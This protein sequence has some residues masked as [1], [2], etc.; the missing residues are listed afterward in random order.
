M[1]IK[2][3][4]CLFFLIWIEKQTHEESPEQWLQGFVWGQTFLW[5]TQQGQKHLEKE[6]HSHVSLDLGAIWYNGVC[7]G[8]DYNISTAE[9]LEWIMDRLS[10]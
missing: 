5:V 1:Q 7:K 9:L 8:S 4:K 2:S 3:N 6:S 10:Y